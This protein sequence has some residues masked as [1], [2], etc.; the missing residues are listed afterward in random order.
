MRKIIYGGVRLDARADF[1]DTNL[2]QSSFIRKEGAVALEGS[3]HFE[4]NLNVNAEI[5]WSGGNRFEQNLSL[6][7]IPHQAVNEVQKL[8]TQNVTHSIPFYNARLKIDNSTQFIDGQRSQ[9]HYQG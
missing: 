3:V 8:K 5:K 1:R 4:N 9:A 2:L 6:T 7:C